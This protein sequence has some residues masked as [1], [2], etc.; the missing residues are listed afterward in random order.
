[1][2]R[3]QLS[4][5][6]CDSLVAGAGAAAWVFEAGCPAAAVVGGGADVT[7]AGG[8]V[9]HAAS[10]QATHSENVVRI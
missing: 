1:L 3:A 7:S 10:K 8:V 9:A 6:A 4:V 5:A 2:L